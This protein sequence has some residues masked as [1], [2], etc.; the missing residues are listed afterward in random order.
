MMP[1]SLKQQ[2]DTT[3]KRVLLFWLHHHHRHHYPPV[4][5][6]MCTLCFHTDL[7][8]RLNSYLL[9]T[10]K[11]RQTSETRITGEQPGFLRVFKLL[12]EPRAIRRGEGGWGRSTA[13]A[14]LT[15]LI[16]FRHFCIYYE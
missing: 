1:V 2:R 13:A 6:E 9:D 4:S 5:L 10:S 14:L 8:S 3:N 15:G 11:A 7:L 12:S 16:V